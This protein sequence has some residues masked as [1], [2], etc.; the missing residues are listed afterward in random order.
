MSMSS[1]TSAA[2]EPRRVSEGF[3]H[4]RAFEWLSRGGFVAR[5]FVYAIVGILA[6]RLALGAGGKLVDQEGAFHAVAHQP[7]GSLL[8]TLLAIGLAAYALWRLVRAAIGHGPEGVDSGADRVV[9]FASGLVYAG[10]C[11]LALR[12]LTGSS[13]ATS[14]S[15]ATGGVLG[16]PAG[17]WL[18]GIAG[19]IFVGIALY[20]GYRGVTKDFLDDA[21]TETM[22]PA[23]RAWIGW[24]GLLGYL[25]R[26]VVFGLV[27]V[28]LI[29]AA[30]DFNPKDAVGLDGALAKLL[31]Q[32]YGPV[33]LGIV[34]VGLIAFALYS[35]SDARYRRI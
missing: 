8:L 35:W 9:A 29:R 20:Q 11:V 4:S 18:V 3:V 27:G 10:L 6:F 12:V 2:P 5:G 23:T 26:M 13:G 25:A 24:I 17:T 7:F 31:Q 28:F 32:P 21:K 22:G 16:W 19:L 14:P 1:A 33:L 34:A 30:L 15:K